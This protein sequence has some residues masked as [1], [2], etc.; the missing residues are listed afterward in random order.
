MQNT[1]G[2]WDCAFKI[3]NPKSELPLQIG[4]ANFPLCLDEA[5]QPCYNASGLYHRTLYS[6]LYTLALDDGFLGQ[7][8]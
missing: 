3:R 4:T 8:A 2:I 5:M 7:D 1:Y 6:S